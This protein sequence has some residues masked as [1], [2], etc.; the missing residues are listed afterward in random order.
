VTHAH[1]WG[2]KLSGWDILLGRTDFAFLVFSFIFRKKLDKH[3]TTMTA[4][5]DSNNSQKDD[6][7]EMDDEKMNEE[8][9]GKGDGQGMDEEPEVHDNI[10][11]VDTFLRQ[12]ECQEPNFI[13]SRSDSIA[14]M[15]DLLATPKQN[16]NLGARRTWNVFCM[17]PK[18]W[19]LMFDDR[20]YSNDPI[21]IGDSRALE[22]HNYKPTTYTEKF[23]TAH[24]KKRNQ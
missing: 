20:D 5:N 24:E 12:L 15:P 6:K 7:E 8:D 9:E 1:I 21:T 10:P 2:K 11:T 18:A 14:A 22:L 23:F 16:L 4:D 19:F 13:Q 3:S 17:T